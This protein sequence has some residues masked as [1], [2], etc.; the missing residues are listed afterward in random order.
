M[1]LASRSSLA[2][3]AVS[4]SGFCSVNQSLHGNHQESRCRR[5]Y[6]WSSGCSWPISRDTRFR[7]IFHQ[8]PT[9][10][11][12]YKATCNDVVCGKVSYDTSHNQCLGQYLIAGYLNACMGWSEDFFKTSDCVTLG[13]EWLTSGVYRPN[14]HATWN[15]GQIVLYFENT[16]S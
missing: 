8:C 13:N 15:T 14:A 2:C 1:T 3:Q 12:Y 11:P 9:H 5:P 4:P 10:S 7:D 6:Y 16:Q